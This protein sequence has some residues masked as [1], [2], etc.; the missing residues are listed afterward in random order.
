MPPHFETLEELLDALA[1]SKHHLELHLE[2]RHTL[3][4]Y[5]EEWQGKAYEELA[6]MRGMANHGAMHYTADVLRDFMDSLAGY[7]SPHRFNLRVHLPR[8][9]EGAQALL[10]LAVATPPDAPHVVEAG[11]AYAGSLGGLRA[12]SFFEEQAAYC[13]VFVDDA[14]FLG[15][16]QLPAILVPN[17]VGGAKPPS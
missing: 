16:W 13:A 10:W 6:L 9:R 3:R 5:P 1:V 17:R 7:I 12:S 2:S 4:A 15:P 14:S 8:F 11:R